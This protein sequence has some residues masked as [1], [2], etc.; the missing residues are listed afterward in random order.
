MVGTTEEKFT[1]HNRRFERYRFNLV[2]SLQLGK[3][4]VSI[5]SLFHLQQD[6]AYHIVMLLGNHIRLL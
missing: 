5:V 1:P 3:I 4:G 2:S 6:I